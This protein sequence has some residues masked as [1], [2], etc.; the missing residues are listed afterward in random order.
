MTT[1]SK[2]EPLMNAPAG[3]N[4]TTPVT[5][6]TEPAPPAEEH[7]ENDY[8][9]SRVPDS[10]KRGAGSILSVLVGFVTAFFFPLIGGLYLTRNGAAATWVGLSISFCI[11]IV[12]A[13]IV[14]RTASRE[15]L[16]SNC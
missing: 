15:G 13:L 4:V 6:W 9:R 3:A 10:A 5:G 1:S 16:T 14:S 2:G 8:A 12:L 11:L 7:D